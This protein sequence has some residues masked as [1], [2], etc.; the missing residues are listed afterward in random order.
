MVII[1]VDDNR[2]DLDLLSD[3]IY[4]ASPD[5]EILE[6]DD[7]L[8]ALSHA[9]ENE[10][11]V[12]FL[13]AD[14]PELGGLELGRYLKE[15]NPKVNI[16]L[17]SHGKDESFDALSMHASGYI[18]KPSSPLCVE[19]ELQDLRY[20]EF[21]KEH[22]R[23]FA[24]TFGNFEFFV[25]GTPVDFKYKRT[26]EIVALLVNNRGAQTTNGEI[27]ASLWEDDGDPDK[28]LSY[29]CNLRQDLQNTFTRLKLDGILIKQRGSMAIAK[30]KIEC[31]LYDYLEKKERSKYTYTGEYMTQYSW[32][33][34]YMAELDEI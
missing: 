6:F 15:L 16:I 20:P 25:D 18:L 7:P 4:D 28:K 11:D 3:L 13:D 30:D 9:R 29:L 24:Q 26:K 12:A 8:A 32:S 21:Q 23:V 33:E 1:A 17:L 5:D 22:K 2:D 19:T 10:V 34:F 31:D 27:I 14:M